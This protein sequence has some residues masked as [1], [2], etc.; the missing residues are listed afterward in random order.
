MN[1][2]GDM[3]NLVHDLRELAPEGIDD[4]QYVRAAMLDAAELIEAHEIGQDRLLRI[5]GR[6]TQLCDENGIGEK[7]RAVVSEES[8]A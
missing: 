3:H 5:I 6:L 2:L 7:A 1:G 8:Q 4:W